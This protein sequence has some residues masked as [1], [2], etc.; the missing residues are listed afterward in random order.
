MR[1]EYKAPEK[2]AAILRELA[3]EIYAV[4][5][6][7]PEHFCKV[8][9]ENR[10]ALA[11]F[12]AFGMPADGL[13]PRNPIIVA[14]GDSVT[15]G[16]FEPLGKMEDFFEKFE[17]GRLKEEDAIEVT[18]ARECYLEK[19]RGMLIDEYEQTSVSTIN[20]GIAGDTIIGMRDRLYRD[21]IQHHPDL[22]LS[23]ASLNWS[24]ECGDTAKY[25][26]VLLD[27]VKTIKKELDTEIILMTPN[28]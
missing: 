6:K 20:S 9:N 26:E 25:E 2:Y 28:I 13:Q 15:A 18:D 7:R 14:L 22:V 5:K 3:E 24:Q 4:S 12:T 19:L 8:M 16:H 1:T 23:I 17:S 27:V 10:G 11:Q 21:V